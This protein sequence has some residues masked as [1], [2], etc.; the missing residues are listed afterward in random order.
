MTIKNI[1]VSVIILLLSVLFFGCAADT[2][3]WGYNPL[4][5]YRNFPMKKVA[6]VAFNPSD[7]RQAY[8]DIKFDYGVQQGIIS[9]DNYVYLFGNNVIHY[10][11]GNTTLYTFTS[12]NDITYLDANLKYIAYLSNNNLM[13]ISTNGSNYLSI[14]VDPSNFIAVLGKG[15][16]DLL[17]YGEKKLD[18]DYYG[19]MEYFG[20][21]KVILYNIV[22]K[23]TDSLPSSYGLVSF[24]KNSKY[25]F[26]TYFTGND[27]SKGI[28]EFSILSVYNTENKVN[29]VIGDLDYELSN[30]NRRWSD[31][32]VGITEDL[33]KFYVYQTR[34]HAYLHPSETSVMDGQ[35]A[36]DILGVWEID[37]S[38]LGLS[39]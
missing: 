18:K 14:T 21:H 29:T 36:D 2:S 19:D 11:N 1:I 33:T 35:D 9:S 24:T 34:T 25:L 3:D 8:E 26:F 5:K 20:N 23:S 16:S 13:V 15:D 38:S 39:E 4:W 28:H 32:T 27:N 37:I 17:A 10:S 30:G 7:L 12:T 31:A 6:N 22:T